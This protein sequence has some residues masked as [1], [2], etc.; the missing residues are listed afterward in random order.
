VHEWSIVASLLAE[1]DRH[2]AAHGARGVRRV[3]LR[4][5][6]LAGV[7]RPLLE[8]AWET[9]RAGTPC[10][11]AELDVRCAPARWRCGPCSRLLAPGARLRCPDCGAPAHLAEGDEILLERLELEVDDEPDP[12]ATPS[13]DTAKGNGSEQSER[14]ERERSEACARPAD[15]ATRR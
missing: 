9:F 6:E 2:T 7:E 4:L 5:G 3:Q 1:I 15:A 8:A 11:A 12:A 13:P 10:A 14:P